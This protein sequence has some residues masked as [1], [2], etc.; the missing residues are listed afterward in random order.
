MKKQLFDKGMELSVDTL[1]GLFVFSIKSVIVL[2]EE[3]DGEEY[4][5]P[6]FKG[7]MEIILDTEKK[8]D[9]MVA[10]DD[11]F[12]GSMDRDLVFKLF[13]SLPFQNQHGVLT[14]M[15]T[16][17]KILSKGLETA[18]GKTRKKQLE[19]YIN[20]KDLAKLLV[21]F[22]NN[23]IAAN[24][25]GETLDVGLDYLE[26]A[27]GAS[28]WKDDEDFAA[29]AASC[30][31]LI[32]DFRAKFGKYDSVEAFDKSLY[33]LC[34]AMSG[35]DRKLFIFDMLM[36]IEDYFLDEIDE[37]EEEYKGL[38]MDFSKYDDRMSVIVQTG[39]KLRQRYRDDF[40]S[41]G[42]EGD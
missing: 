37:L 20:V 38:E 18:V 29:H 21:W 42:E 10:A 11:F 36:D 24:V 32:K 25:Y 35:K 5:V 34:D 3:P 9:E 14:A 2:L 40:K 26:K 28:D 1:L 12:D 31:T 33:E 8:I 19:L 16:F 30:L 6:E 23:E 17:M 4:E 22:R 27:L 39:W 13:G 7:I 15:T 41:G